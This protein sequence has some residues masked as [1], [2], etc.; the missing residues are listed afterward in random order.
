MSKNTLI[1]LGASILLILLVGGLILF[2]APRVGKLGLFSASP[3]GS[4]RLPADTVQ[5]EVIQI[6][7]EGEITLDE[8][9]QTYQ[10][11]LIQLL[12]GTYAGRQVIIDYGQRQVRPEGMR[13]QTGEKILVTVG[14][15]ENGQITAYFTDF[16]RTRSLLWLAGAFVVLTILISGWKGVR[17]LIGLALSLVVI[18][19][20]IIP[21][22]LQGEDPVRVSI[23]G[24][25]IL[26]GITLYLVYGWTLKTHAAAISMLL[27]LLIT[28]LLS[29]YF[30]NLTRLT[31]FGS[32]NAMFLVQMAD[33]R[34]NLR[35]LVLAGM[36]IGALGVLDDLV[37][38]QSSAVFELRT[39]DPNLDLHGLYG[40]AMRIG[41]DHVAATVNTLFLA[42]AGAALPMLLLFSL[43]G[44]RYGYL[45][46]LE[47]VTE[48]IVRTLVGSLGLIMAVPIST[49]LASLLALY[50]QRLGSLRRY[51]GPDNSGPPDHGHTHA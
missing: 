37:T 5:A 44:E 49:M 43:S 23:I 25:F 14:Q 17:S 31:G 19:A 35:G 46:N 32:E 2:L 41:R 10:I 1:F 48:E 47:F 22:I 24:A 42:Y 40:S 39:A 30:V 6:I 34:I 8:S 51:L 11:L 26:L 33:A 27:T 45:V 21:S 36:L 13:I 3:L 12:E 38:S 9:P 16:V 18:I 29:S 7:E 4:S 28:G 20:Y 15:K 50:N